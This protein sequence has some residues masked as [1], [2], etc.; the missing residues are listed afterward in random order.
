[1][2]F[3]A[4]NLDILEETLDGRGTFHVTQM[5][6]YQRGPK[7]E[8]HS[9]ENTSTGRSKSL[10]CVPYEF[11]QLSTIDVPVQQVYP[12]FLEPV[13]ADK[14]LCPLTEDDD[15][16]SKDLAWLVSRAQNTEHQ[17]VP[18]WTGFNQTVKEVSPPVTTVAYLPI[19]PAPV[20]TWDTIFNVLLRCKQIA[21]KL[22]KATTVVTFDEALCCKGTELVL[23]HPLELSDVVIRLGGFHSAQNYLGA[24]G[25]HME[26]SELF[27]IWDESG[28]CKESIANNILAGKS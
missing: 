1:M 20:H 26:D 23:A 22:N 12:K 14:V 27:D 3:A 17:V 10:I 24:I 8:Q 7:N 19:V 6:A 18:S 13:L 15:H 2:Q 11:H 16:Q 4:D 9:L 28:V 21:L 5:A 25:K